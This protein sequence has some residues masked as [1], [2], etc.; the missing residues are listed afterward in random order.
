MKGLSGRAMT[1]SFV[2]NISESSNGAG[3]PR[4]AAVVATAEDGS[5]LADRDVSLVEG[6]DM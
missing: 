1:L 3:T 2:V 4:R 5:P 6:A